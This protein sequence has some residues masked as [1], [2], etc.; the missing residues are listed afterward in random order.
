[1]VHGPG[2]LKSPWGREDERRWER[3]WAPFHRKVLGLGPP[4]SP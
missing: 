3:G 1:M 4:D 2:S